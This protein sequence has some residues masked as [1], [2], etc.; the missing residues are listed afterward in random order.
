MIKYPFLIALC[1]IVHYSFSQSVLVPATGNTL[2]SGCNFTI[3]DPGGDSNF[4]AN[5]SGSISICPSVQGQRVHIDFSVLDLGGGT[6]RVR[7]GSLYNNPIIATITSANQQQYS[8]FTSTD[9]MGCITIDFTVF[10]SSNLM[11]GFV[12]Q[13]TCVSPYPP[14]DAAVTIVINSGAPFYTG[15]DL[16]FSLVTKNLGGQGPV[17]AHRTK[18]FLSTDN[19][20]SVDDAEMYEFNFSSTLQ[21]GQSTGNFADNFVLPDSLANGSYYLLAVC[22]YYNELTEVN[23]SNNVAVAGPFNLQQGAID[24]KFL[25]STIADTLPIGFT[26]SATVAFT[27]IGVLP[28]S[29]STSVIYLS[30]DSVLDAGDF[31]ID[32]FA[33][34]SIAPGASFNSSIITMALPHSLTEGI[35]Y[36][37]IRADD[38]EYIPESNE[39]NNTLV[40]KITLLNPYFDFRP[41]FTNAPAIMRCNTVYTVTCRVND[42]G[43]FPDIRYVSLAY[44]LSADS[45]WDATDALVHSSDVIQIATTFYNSASSITLP[46][47][48]TPGNYYLIARIDGE[49]DFLETNELNNTA[50][51]PVT[52]LPISY[53]F[54]AHNITFPDTFFANTGANFTVNCGGSWSN[55]GT[56]PASPV[57][58]NVYLSAD[59]IWSA[60]DLSVGGQSSSFLGLNAQTISDSYNFNAGI[61][62]GNYYLLFVCDAPNTFFELNENNNV[63][64][65]P[66][67]IIRKDYDFEITHILNTPLVSNVR[68]GNMPVKTVYRGNSAYTTTSNIYYYLSNDTLLSASDS[69]IGTRTVS[70]EGYNSDTV[71][72][73][74][75]I[76]N[77]PPGN[78]YLLAR[79]DGLDA[80]AE[81]NELNNLICKP[82]LLRPDTVDIFFGSVGVGNS[83]NLVTGVTTGFTLQL[84]DTSITGSWVYNVNYTLYSSAD[85]LYQPG[86][87]VFIGDGYSSRIYS[88]TT[89]SFSPNYVVP[90]AS[91]GHSYILYRA[92]VPDFWH[93]S[94]EQNNLAYKPVNISAP[95]RNLYPYNPAVS[96]SG[97]LYSGTSCNFTG[98]VGN[99]GNSTP[100]GSSNFRVYLSLDSLFNG[101][102]VLIY[103]YSI[104]YYSLPPG[105]STA[106]SGSGVVNGAPGNYFLLYVA[107]ATNQVT[108][109]NEADNVVNI[110]VTIIP[111]PLPDVEV[112]ETIAGADMVTV[113]RSQN[114]YVMVKNNANLLVSN[115]NVSF[116]LSSDTIK[117]GTDPLIGTF[118]VNNAIAAS[119][120]ENIT[121]NTTIPANTLPGS[122]YLIA[123]ADAGSVLAELNENNN[124]RYVPV[125]VIDTTADIFLV[126]ANNNAYS[127]VSSL[128]YTYPTVEVANFGNSPV[129]AFRLGLYLSTDSVVDGNDV[130]ISSSNVNG[131][132]RMAHQTEGFPGVAFPVVTPGSYYLIAFADDQSAIGETRENNNLWI[133]PANVAARFYDVGWQSIS[134]PDTSLVRGQS[135]VLSGVLKNYGNSSTGS[136]ANIIML[137][138]DTIL[139]ANDVQVSSASSTSIA[140]NGQHLYATT[141]NISPL[142]VPGNY[143]LICYADRSTQ[144]AE[145]NEVN[146]YAHIAITVVGAVHDLLIDSI[147]VD[148]AIM[149]GRTFVP[150]QYWIKNAGNLY[151]GAEASVFL[152]TDTILTIG[153][154]IQLSTTNT[155]Y[156]SPGE[157]L[158]Q[159]RWFSVGANVSPGNYY[160]LILEDDEY[161]VAEINE[162]NNLFIQPV[163]ILPHKIDVGVSDFYLTNANDEFPSAGQAIGINWEVSN[164]T[165]GVTSILARCKIL[166][167]DDTLVSPLD[168]RIHSYNVMLNGDQNY[169]SLTGSISFSLP[170]NITP[171]L[172]Y[173]ICWMDTANVNNDPNLANN[174][175]LIPFYVLAPNVDLY[176]ANLVSYNG[177][178][179]NGGTHSISFYNNGSTA[180][181]QVRYSVY[182]SQDSTTTTGA[183]LYLQGTVDVAAFG[184]R[185]VSF[186]NT[187]GPPAG[188][189]YMIV[190]V[191]DLQQS[192]EINETNNRFVKRVARQSSNS[193]YLLPDS[194]MAQPY[195]LDCGD[196]IAFAG[197]SGHNPA[198][199]TTILKFV[200]PSNNYG[201]IFDSYSLSGNSVLNVYSGYSTSGLPV[202]SYTSTNLPGIVHAANDSLTLELIAD[203]VNPG[204]FRSRVYCYSASADLQILQSTFNVDTVAGNINYDND[205][206]VL[207]S[208]LASAGI[209]EVEIR[210]STDSIW[211]SND[212]YLAIAAVPTLVASADI[213]VNAAFSLPTGY[214]EGNYFI[215]VKADANNTVAEVNEN[216]NVLAR[217]VYYKS[218]GVGMP[219]LVAAVAFYNWVDDSRQIHLVAQ[220]VEPFS[221][222]LYNAI[223]QKVEA[224]SSAGV[225]LS[226]NSLP[227]GVYLAAITQ[228]GK[229][230]RMKIVIP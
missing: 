146:N 180:S 46:D 123:F 182:L 34:S 122:Y 100:V 20:Y 139:D 133:W 29:A 164:Y 25:S 11:A 134:L 61:A 121:V 83:G 10:N 190:D 159:A 99:S 124:L 228:Y 173:F 131:L 214:A 193:M 223:G 175:R 48:T 32:T 172:H 23:E 188:I 50:S 221:A 144:L 67:V 95:N 92:D 112:I 186:S 202:A 40:K 181:G 206:T 203:A 163:T 209:S 201:L 225:N 15:E 14:S 208:G 75:V 197:N 45:I 42:A 110:P 44:F 8:N 169:G 195:E 177:Y 4:P 36:V 141:V 3:K 230:Y 199:Q 85:T 220:N 21:P 113:G 91:L 136:F 226:F 194:V 153:T 26:E 55:A 200:I 102:D 204:S 16:D 103:D 129:S 98:R 51:T 78:Y 219:E 80:T 184:N 93:E 88:N 111:T 115:F 143:Y 13:A 74:V 53:D 81:L 138:T 49:N 157:R 125:E 57:Y 171:G 217:A 72:A 224:K 87:D 155:L 35:Y 106:V 222:E 43:I 58:L 205:V 5:T 59:T 28:S 207:N 148:T 150:L 178:L 77:V 160:L 37:I 198:T 18:L 86:S 60:D 73:T 47:F 56:F 70:F 97:P 145:T 170:G 24:L 126:G 165:F 168:K 154:D 162:A 119:D 132:G 149:A 218:D 62:T 229:S 84:K 192:T 31:P 79:A 185:T 211:S 140:V 215:L 105:G 38:R 22:D 89:Q 187:S 135:I 12:A 130:L 104:P 94:N 174:K 128:S 183:Y 76:P 156:V 96:I 2:I 107:D 127:F 191:D 147:S 101:G 196:T 52:V 39:A 64:V 114:H 116:F 109:L 17:A 33:L 151:V 27:N 19:S 227:S 82:I 108:E 189:Y 212:V 158:F 41:Q 65:K 210:F 30:Y 69:L 68:Q 6:L 54:Y 142:T 7:N 120:V 90:A 63:F 176:P 118:L 167:S 137:S 1:F 161:A 213:I 216:N 117:D 66:F 179:V 71:N 152:S 166:L 9:L